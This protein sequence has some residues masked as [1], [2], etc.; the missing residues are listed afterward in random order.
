[1]PT[2]AAL[3]TATSVS[4]NFSA[5][6]LFTQTRSPALAQSTS[7]PSRLL[8]PVPCPPRELDNLISDPKDALDVSC[9]L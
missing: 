1:L 4:F 6:P 9:A 8:D 5:S 3:A 7:T 2:L